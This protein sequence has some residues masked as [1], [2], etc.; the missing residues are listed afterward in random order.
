MT[1]SVTAVFSRVGRYATS[2]QIPHHSSLTPTSRPRACAIDRL[3]C[4]CRVDLHGRDTKPD[5]FRAPPVAG[6]TRIRA[7]R[8]RLPAPSGTGLYISIFGDREGP[9]I[10]DPKRNWTPGQLPPAHYQTGPQPS[11]VTKSSGPPGRCV[12]IIR[13]R[14]LGSLRRNDNRPILL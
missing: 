13:R 4:R 9:S 14:D 6:G 10:I 8:D 7:V 5:A 2:Y 1:L 12:C 3:K 11:P